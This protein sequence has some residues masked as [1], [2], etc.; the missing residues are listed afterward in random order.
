MRF[1]AVP[2]CEP[3]GDGVHVSTVRALEDIEPGE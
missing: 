1:D 3:E 2:P